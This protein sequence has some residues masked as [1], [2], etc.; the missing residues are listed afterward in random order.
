MSGQKIKFSK[1]TLFFRPKTPIHQKQML[2]NILGMQVVKEMDSYLGLPL[3]VGKNKTNVFKYIFDRFTNRIKGWSKRL[4]SSGG[5][6][7]FV[8][9]ILQSLPT[10]M[11]FVFLLLWGIINSMVAKIHNFWWENRNEGHGWAMLNWQR[12]CIPKGMGAWH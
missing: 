8:K 7:V 4:H 12:V 9:A 1:S 6:K 3:V 10:Y 5:K 2:S 11:F